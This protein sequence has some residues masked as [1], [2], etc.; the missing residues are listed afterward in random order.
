MYV[1]TL[2]ELDDELLEALF[3]AYPVIATVYGFAG[4]RDRLLTDFR[5]SSEQAMGGAWLPSLSEPPR[6]TQIR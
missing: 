4:P 5:E 2:D 1:T 3:D 6:S